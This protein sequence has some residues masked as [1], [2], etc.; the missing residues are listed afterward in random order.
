MNIK[1]YKS[2]IIGL[3]CLGI[4]MLFT[5]T[6]CRTTAPETDTIVMPPEIKFSHGYQGEVEAEYQA[7]NKVGFCCNYWKDLNGN[8]NAEFPEEYIGIKNRFGSNEKLAFIFIVNDTSMQGKAFK[9]N[10][11][12]PNGNSIDQAAY[13]IPA[14]NVMI[15]MAGE[16]NVNISNWLLSL[17]GPGTYKA[18]WYIGNVCQGY[19]EFDIFNAS[20]EATAKNQTYTVKK[21]DTL[22]GIARKFKIRQSEITKANKISNPNKIF[23]GQKLLIPRR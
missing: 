3:S 17:G 9:V 2:N 11:V 15:H 22:S 19:S 10:I 7:R 13:S 1:Y 6:S 16:P 8:G 12:G 4:S 21:G 18:A 20:T 23:A 14:N 5:A